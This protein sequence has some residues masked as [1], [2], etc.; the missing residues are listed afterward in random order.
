M[1]QQAKKFKK[2]LGGYKVDEVNEYLDLVI[3]NYKR[4]L[5]ESKIKMVSNDKMQAKLTADD[6]RGKIF[7]RSLWGY[8][9]KEVDRFIDDVFRDFLKWE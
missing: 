8:D 7:K 2:T 4:L 3:R 9:K 6:I 5:K 1:R